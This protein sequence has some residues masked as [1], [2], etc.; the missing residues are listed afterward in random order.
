MENASVSL[1]Q[2]TARLGDQLVGSL[3]ASRRE[4]QELACLETD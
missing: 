2:R 3:K 4:V 1:E